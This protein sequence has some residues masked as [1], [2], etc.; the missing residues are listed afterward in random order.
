MTSCNRRDPGVSAEDFRAMVRKVAKRHVL[1]N[2][3]PCTLHLVVF[4]LLD[5][6]IAPII[7]GHTDDKARNSSQR[8]FRPRRR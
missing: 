4:F 5:P 6:K 7:I 2:P 3:N 1:G 8:R